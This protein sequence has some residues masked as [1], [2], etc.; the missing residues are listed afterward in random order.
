[1]REAGG[2]ISWIKENQLGEDLENSAII[3]FANV[4]KDK[5]TTADNGVQI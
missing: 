3:L 5:S 2:K 4:E 1:M